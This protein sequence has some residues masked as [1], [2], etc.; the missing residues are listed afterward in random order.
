LP[1]TQAANTELAQERARASAQVAPV[2]LARRKFGL[3]DV[4]WALMQPN[5]VFHSLRR[6]HV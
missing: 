4:L 3:L 2:V 1:E 5:T 6:R